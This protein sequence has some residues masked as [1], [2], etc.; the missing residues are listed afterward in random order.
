M[1]HAAMEADIGRMIWRCEL[2]RSQ[3]ITPDFACHAGGWFLRYADYRYPRRLNRRE[4]HLERSRPA[5]QSLGRHRR[6]VRR[7]HARQCLEDRVPWLARQFARGLDRRDPRIVDLAERQGP[8]HNVSLECAAIA[9][10]LERVRRCEGAAAPSGKGA[11][12]RHARA[13]EARL[14]P[15]EGAGRAGLRPDARGAAR[16]SPRHG[17]RGGGVPE[18]RRVLG[19]APRHLHAD[20]RYLHARLRL[21]QCAH[22]KARRARCRA[23][24]PAWQAPSPRSAS[25]M[26]W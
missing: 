20:G 4:S 13:A 18:Y 17:V 8:R 10:L 14:D 26:W 15:G 21:L 25:P 6:L 3:W 2:G 1:R 11:A 16:A 24:R 23:S 9:T 5:H 12:A 7:R 22:G 19:Q